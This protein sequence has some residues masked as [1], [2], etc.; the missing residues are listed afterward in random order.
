MLQLIGTGESEAGRGGT[1]G[2][3]C[4]YVQTILHEVLK[5]LTS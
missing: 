1:E 3:A 5:E 4:E 2:R